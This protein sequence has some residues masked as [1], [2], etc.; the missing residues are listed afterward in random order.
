[1]VCTRLR[2]LHGLPLIVSDAHE[3]L[4]AARKA[5]FPSVLWQR[6]QFHLQQNAGEYVPVQALRGQ[7]ATEI[8]SIFNSP[9]RAEADRL[10]ELFVQRHTEKMPKLA[11][12]AETPYRKG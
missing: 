9:D 7:I 3:G 12:W 11:E 10:L 6:C 2:G 4:K 1:M 5:V 8:K